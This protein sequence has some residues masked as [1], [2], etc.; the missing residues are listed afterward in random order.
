M[1][2]LVS[3]NLTEIESWPRHFVPQK[4]HSFSWAAHFGRGVCTNNGLTKHKGRHPAD[5]T[6]C[7]G[8]S[9]YTLTAEA[10]STHRPMY[11]EISNSPT[12]LVMRRLCGLFAKTT[13]RKLK[14]PWAGNA[15][16][17][18]TNRFRLKRLVEECTSQGI[19]RLA[20]QYGVVPPGSSRRG[21]AHREAESH[22]GAG[23]IHVFCLS[24]PEHTGGHRL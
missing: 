13:L 4:Q 10:H 14:G 20:P 8:T 18:A 12:I 5:N 7:K 19:D 24:S 3:I 15:G 22:W 6:V 2:T 21:T 1:S 23:H 16:N 11:A 9:A 17:S